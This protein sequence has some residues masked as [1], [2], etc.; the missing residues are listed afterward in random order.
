MRTINKLIL[1][2]GLAIVLT[3]CMAIFAATTG[4]VEGFVKDE[5]TGEPILKAKITFVSAKSSQFKTRIPFR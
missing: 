3:F 5:Q 4:A 1:L 2:F